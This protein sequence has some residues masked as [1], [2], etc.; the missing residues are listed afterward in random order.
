MCRRTALFSCFNG[1]SVEK[2]SSLYIHIPFCLRKCNYCAFDSTVGSRALRSVYLSALKKEL[3][4]LAAQQRL[5]STIFFGGGTPTSYS[6]DELVDLI[7]LVRDCFPV[8]ADAE[9]SLEAN[10]GTVD[11]RYLEILRASGVNRLS[12]G[13][14]SFDDQL[15]GRLGRL[16]SGAEARKAVL[17]AQAAGFTNI[18]LD[19][20]SALPGQ[21]ALLWQ[22]DLEQALALR[23]QHLSLYQLTIEENTPFAL[24]AHQRRLQLPEEEEILEIDEMTSRLTRSAGFSHYEISNYCREGFA[25]RHNINYWENGSY[26]AA[27]AGAVS[28]LGGLRQRRVADPGIYADRVM[29]DLSP[30]VEEESLAPERSFCETVIMGLRMRRGVSLKRLR[31]VYNLEPVAFYGET[32][33]SLF[34]SGLIEIHSGYLRITDKGL[35]LANTIMA[36]L[37]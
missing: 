23:P 22:R 25:C 30:V 17:A 10:P 37:V 26:L 1:S 12:L 3:Q 36:E 6:A 9:I 32:L 18:N 28:F 13:V 15:L 11:E 33:T 31:A 20:M 5:L 16:H 24:L 2:L 27:G 7:A 35:P 21:D 19:L 29:H 34:D 14:Q 4:G 8:A